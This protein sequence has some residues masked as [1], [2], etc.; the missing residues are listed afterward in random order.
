AGSQTINVS[1]DVYRLAA[2]NTLGAV[3]FGNVH[4]GDSVQQALSITNTAAND[5]FSEK[6][7][8]SFGASSDARITTSGGVSLLAAGSTDSSSMLVGLDTSAA[9]NVN[10][11]QVINFVSDGSG[12]SGL[13]V[14]ALA[15][16][17][18]G[19]SGDIVTN[20]SVFRLASASPATPNPVDFGSVRIG[21]TADQALSIT[22]TAANDG[23]SEKL[24]ASISS[25]GTPVTASGAFDLLAAQGTDSGSLHVGIDTGSAGA[26]SGSATIA[27]VSDGTGTSGLGTTNLTPQTVNVSGDVYRLAD[28]TLNTSSVTLAARRG[29]AAPTAAI[30]VSNSSPDNFTEGLKAGIGATPAGFTGSGSIGNLAA[31]GTDAGSLQVALDTGIAGSFGGDARLDFESTGAGTTGAADISVGSQLVS[32]AGKV[33]EKAIAQVN[34][35]LVDFGI[36]HKGDVV[37]AKNVSVSNGA[38]VAGLNDTLQGSFINMPSGPFGG[39]GSVD[40]AAG[41]SDASSLLVSLDT[42][43]AGVFSSSGDRLQ[44]ASHNPDMADLALANASLALQAQVNNYVDPTFLK[45]SGAGVLSGTGLNFMLDFGTL[46]QGSGMVSALLALANDASGP[47]DLLDGAYALAVSDF[48]KSGFVDF[49]DLAAGQ[50]QGGLQISLETL[51]VGNFSD[52]IVLSALGHNASGFSAAFGDVTL[53]VQAR[54]QAG[55]GQIPE[56]GSLLLLTIALAIIVLQ[57][58]RGMLD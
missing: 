40:V 10:G 21:S 11:T 37:T 35:A 23:F 41:Q 43:N 51:N 28:P 57:R 53:T 8:A 16:Q 1:G 46:T 47:A 26:K 52:T 58:R 17:T 2:A 55:G 32:L 13:G 49:T 34:T 3:A 18:I 5:G 24:N 50:S 45:T 33:Y 31:Q 54:V 42:S 27:L 22:N 19:V 15:S 12:T 14:S 6:L 39:S 9:G 44:F 4:V 20:G 36:V 56:P 7:T 29:D 25:N 30:S 38:A 48:L